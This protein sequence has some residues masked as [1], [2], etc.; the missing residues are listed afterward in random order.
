M[1]AIQGKGL[2]GNFE[3]LEGRDWLVREGIG[4]QFENARGPANNR[5]LDQTRIMRIG[6]FFFIFL[7]TAGSD[8]LWDLVDQ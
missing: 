6:G 4:R 3:M 8:M 7:V 5:N 1:C 2:V